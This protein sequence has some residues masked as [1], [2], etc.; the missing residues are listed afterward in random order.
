MNK[1]IALIA[2]TSLIATPLYADDSHHP[3]KQQDAAAKATE[4][5]V[6]ADQQIK[7]AQ[8]VVKKMQEQMEKI[9]LTKDPTER[10]RLMQEHM[11]TFREGMKILSGMGM[12]GGGMMGGNL[13]GRN[14]PGGSMMDG[15]MLGGDMMEMRI[16]MMASMMEQMMQREEVRDSMPPK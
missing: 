16:E 7:Q 13:M 11:Q 12:G 3:E 8:V 4:A 1:L 9:W 2:V 6:N 5:S 14:I 15:N 10:Q